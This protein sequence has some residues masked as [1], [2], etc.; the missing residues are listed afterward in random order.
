MDDIH[1]Y[2]GFVFECNRIEKG[3]EQRKG[4]VAVICS[5]MLWA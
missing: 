4:T 5:V 1:G 3:S 2:L